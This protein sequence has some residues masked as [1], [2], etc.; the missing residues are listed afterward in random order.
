MATE[1]NFLLPLVLPMILALIMFILT[2]IILLFHY[3]FR[4]NRLNAVEAD[5]KKTDLESASGLPHMVRSKALAILPTLPVIQDPDMR[6]SLAL[7]APRSPGS[8]P[9]PPLGFVEPDPEWSFLGYQAA[10]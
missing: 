7:Q 9:N 5:D 6:I 1:V 3:G 2:A 10:V 8:G 4:K